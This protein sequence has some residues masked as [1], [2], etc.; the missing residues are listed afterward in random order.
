MP[1]QPNWSEAVEHIKN[2][3]KR[4][5][6]WIERIGPPNGR[7]RHEHTIFYSLL[8]SIIYQQLAGSAA[9]AILG[10][11]DALSPEGRVTPEFIAEASDDML[12]SAGLSRNKMAALRDLAAKT[13]DGTVPTARSIARMSDEVVIEH[14]TQVKGIGR[15]TVEMLLMFR[16]GR[17][18]V[19]PLDDYGIRKGFQIVYKMPDLPT[20]EQMIKRAEKWRPWRTVGCWYLW[21][22]VEQT[23]RAK[24]KK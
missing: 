6:P 11:V 7:V 24:K 10:R 16:L 15:W 13:L 20:K 14:C 21:R 19:L 8:R 3:D 5:A 23:P 1:R 12:R 9:S 18:D 22:V 17:L 4:M 2:S